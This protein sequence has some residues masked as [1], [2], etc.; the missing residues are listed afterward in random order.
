MINSLEKII[1]KIL[2][3]KITINIDNILLLINLEK[4][5]KKEELN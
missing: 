2:K 4:I 1:I 3:I 5:V